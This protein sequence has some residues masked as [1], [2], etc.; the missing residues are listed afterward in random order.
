MSR[1]VEG[2]HSH[3]SRIYGRAPA[4]KVPALSFELRSKQLLEL[5]AFDP[6]EVWAEFRCVFVYEV[7]CYGRGF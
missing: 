2:L 5:A 3:I 6:L 4:T 7:E 1:S